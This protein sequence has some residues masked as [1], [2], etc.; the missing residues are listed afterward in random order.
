MISR[1][2]PAWTSTVRGCAV[3]A[4]GSSRP[5]FASRVPWARAG[6]K[7]SPRWRAADVR[8][9]VI[10][11]AHNEEE[12]LPVTLAELARE[13]PGL[14]VVVI[15]D[16]SRDRTRLVTREAGAKVIVLPVNLG[17]GGAL[18]TGIRYAFER[19]Y[20]CVVQFDADGQHDPRD[21]PRVLAPV[22]EGQ[23]DLCIGSRFVG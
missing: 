13:A 22:L 8:P 16:G 12:S 3:C 23:V 21:L 1:S 19:G 7:P 2:P 18:Q 15:D 5:G 10:V 4:T 11:P 14:D 17:V 9:L 20:G 6:R